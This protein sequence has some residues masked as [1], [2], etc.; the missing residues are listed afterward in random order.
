MSTIEPIVKY[1]EAFTVTG[2]GTKTINRDEAELSTAKIPSLWQQL[3]SSNLVQHSPVYGVYSDFASDVS[4]FYTITVGVSQEN[5][6]ENAN[7]V[8]VRSGYY[9][10][11]QNK[12]AMPDVVI[13][14]WKQIWDF[15]EKEDKYQRSYLSDFE[16]YSGEDELAIFIGIKK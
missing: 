3:H 2:F 7:Q 12:G 13:N 14:T 15:F 4:D 10:V 1:V 11:F 6:Q 9:P 5:Q 8:T 16:Q